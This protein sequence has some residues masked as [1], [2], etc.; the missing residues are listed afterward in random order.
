[1]IYLTRTYFRQMN[2]LCFL[3]KESIFSYDLLRIIDFRVAT[4][5]NIALDIHL[6]R[7]WHRIMNDCLNLCQNVSVQLW[8]H[9]L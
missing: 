4:L 3:Y 6:L 7:I 2:L 9:S 8:K 1:M 5:K